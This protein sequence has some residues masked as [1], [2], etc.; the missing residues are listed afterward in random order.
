MNRFLW[1]FIQ[2]STLGNGTIVYTCER[3]DPESFQYTRTHTHTARTHTLSPGNCEFM[4]MLNDLVVV[5]SQLYIDVKTSS[6]VS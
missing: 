2:P 3:V 1:G 5:I 6:Y 4:D